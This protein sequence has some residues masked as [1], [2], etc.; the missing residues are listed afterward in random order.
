MNIDFHGT[1]QRA[2]EAFLAGDAAQAESLQAEFLA[3]LKQSIRNGEDYCP[4]P[5]DC[6]LHR[7]CV[8]C[9]A[10]HRGHGH[11]L[12]FC[13]QEMLNRKLLPLSELTEHSVISSIKASACMGGVLS[14]SDVSTSPRF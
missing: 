6:E 12:P 4:C 5:V 8:H 7:N 13:L 9:V 2:M 14:E 1:E 10:V 11:H 3:E